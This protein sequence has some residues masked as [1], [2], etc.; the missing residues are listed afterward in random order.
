[1][2]SVR[3]TGLTVHNNLREEYHLGRYCPLRS[4]QKYSPLL[5]LAKISLVGG[6]PC[7][8]EDSDKHQKQINRKT[9]VKFFCSDSKK[10]MHIVKAYEKKTCSYRV[11]VH[12]PELCFK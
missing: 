5:H 10:S 7:V 6:E 3:Q 8:I 9:K 11:L 4:F 12:V 2:E 1:M